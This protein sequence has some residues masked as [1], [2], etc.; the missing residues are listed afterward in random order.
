ML[1]LLVHFI[2]QNNYISP[3]I[4]GEN[5]VGAFYLI[6]I[7]TPGYPLYSVI[8]KLFT[9]IPVGNYGFR[10]I[11][12][13][14][15]F[16]AITSVIIFVIILKVLHF[17]NLSNFNMYF[18]STAAVLLFNF[19]PTFL[20]HSITA[21]VYSIFS[22]LI[23]LQILLITNILLDNKTS[24]LREC[25]ILSFL[26]G[27]LFSYH[28]Q[29]ALI[30]FLP[31]V[32]FSIGKGS[33][34]HF[35]KFTFLFLLGFSCLI[36]LPLRA[37]ETQPVILSYAENWNN[38]IRCFAKEE[39][40]S[41]I[42]ILNIK[43][44]L[45]TILFF[46]YH[47]IKQA[48]VFFVLFAIVGL[49]ACCGKLLKFLILLFIFNTFI[50]TI[51]LKVPIE[52]YVY[53]ERIWIPA[54][55][56]YFIFIGA[57]ISKIMSKF[58]TRYP[59]IVLMLLIFLF[60]SCARHYFEMKEITTVIPSVYGKKVLSALDKD[61]ILFIN[62]IGFYYCLLYLQHIENV[63]KD[64]SVV[65]CNYLPYYPHR[66]ELQINQ[67]TFVYLTDSEKR[68]PYCLKWGFHNWSVMLNLCDRIANDNI[69][70]R[71]LYFIRDTIFEGIRI[72]KL[73][74]I[75]R[76]YHCYNRRSCLPMIRYKGKISKE[77]LSIYK[78]FKKAISL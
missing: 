70:R 45:L 34:L 20:L 65:C 62:D 72:Y 33:I 10:V 11:F 53:F 78:I 58:H 52:E 46:S 60:N 28:P 29:I 26:L 41:Y 66:K 21:S 50:F 16:I 54:F 68:S 6:P 5:I 31:F 44:Y 27:I 17:Q 67:K 38:F 57:G 30:I 32:Y 15:V 77:E 61:S 47:L 56:I 43:E 1:S 63:R 69:S 75:E 13:S 2:S 51:F 74:K 7:H 19:S 3:G 55:I 73:Q 22:F 59:V 35:C 48:T 71:S 4:D 18:S 24:S 64:I 49:F 40:Y 12:T 8:S 42:K 14:F 39:F 76:L 23:S 36:F 9:Y 25:F 37:T